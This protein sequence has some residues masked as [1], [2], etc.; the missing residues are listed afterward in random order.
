[1]FLILYYHKL[2]GIWNGKIIKQDLK[3]CTW[4]MLPIND[5]HIKGENNIKYPMTDILANLLM[6]PRGFYSYLSADL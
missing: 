5:F 6:L 1:M 3:I 4:P 2:N